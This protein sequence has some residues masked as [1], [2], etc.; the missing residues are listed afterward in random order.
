MTRVTKLKRKTHE[1][2]SP[3]EAK[4][5]PTKRHRFKKPEKVIEEPTKSVKRRERRQKKKLYD[6]VCFQCRKAG[7]S[8][9]NCPNGGAKICYRCGSND[10]SLKNCRKKP[11]KSNIQNESL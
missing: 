11:N 10:H 5:L 1:E 7:H 3:F 4:A 8:A 9:Q 2:A 6:M